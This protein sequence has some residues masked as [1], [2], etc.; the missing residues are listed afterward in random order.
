MVMPLNPCRLSLRDIGNRGTLSKHLANSPTDRRLNKVISMI[1]APDP[2]AA[3][4][5]VVYALGEQPAFKVGD[6]IKVDQRSPVGHYRV[7]T[8]LRGK[9]GVVE[10]VIT[11]VAV[12]NEQEGFGR[13]AGDRLHYYRVSVR[14]SDIWM[15][16]QG[17]P[18]DSLHIEVFETW[19][20]R[21]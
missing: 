20:E 10:A 13:N 18:H 11:P 15:A 6:R 3:R 21:I 8:Y 14:L 9:T 17:P 12:D 16:Y 5:R 2:S 4:P 1:A 19:L 7:P